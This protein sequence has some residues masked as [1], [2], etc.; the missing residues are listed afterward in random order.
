MS[1]SLLVMVL[2]MLGSACFFVG[3]AI[4]L[5]GYLHP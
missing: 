2:Y 1:A 4:S 3:T 5:W